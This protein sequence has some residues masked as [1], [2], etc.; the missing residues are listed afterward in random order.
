MRIFKR[1]VRLNESTED[2]KAIAAAMNDNIGQLTKAL[3]EEFEEL[4]LLDDIEYTSSGAYIVDATFQLTSKHNTLL[5]LITKDNIKIVDD[6][7]MSNGKN[8]HG[9]IEFLSI[10]LEYGPNDNRVTLDTGV[11]PVFDANKS[12]WY[13]QYR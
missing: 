6:M 7:L 10:K 4:I 9:I 1:S 5:T 11:R 8:V 12:K 3:R 2:G 13:L